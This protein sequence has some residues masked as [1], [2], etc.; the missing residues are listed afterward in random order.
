MTDTV[1]ATEHASF[2]S[3]FQRMAKL[4]AGSIRKPSD[5]PLPHPEER[6]QAASRRVG[7]TVSV[8]I[9]RDAALRAAPQDEVGR[10]GISFGRDIMIST[11]L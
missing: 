1:R 11:T 9:L 4:N 10:Y 7:H 3:L 2:S 6:P 5:T 8:A